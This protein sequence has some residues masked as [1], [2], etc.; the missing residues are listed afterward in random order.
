MLI[1][2]KEYARMNNVAAATVRQKILRGNLSAT[3][4]G[5]DWFIEDT[6]EYID[7]RVKTGKYKKAKQE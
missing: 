7:K 4:M 6:Q 5:R 2:L 1:T 3:K